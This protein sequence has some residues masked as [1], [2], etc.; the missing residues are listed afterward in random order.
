M[1]E[2]TA[3]DEHLAL[4]ALYR[5]NEPRMTMV[6]IEEVRIGPIASSY[7]DAARGAI[8]FE[9]QRRW[10]NS[11][12]INPHVIN[13]SGMQAWAKVVILDMVDARE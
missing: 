10:P 12:V 4:L 5:S 2:L 8:V 9:A 1:T 13:F 11:L 3:N 7:E 6:R